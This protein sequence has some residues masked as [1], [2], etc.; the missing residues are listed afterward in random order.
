MN[1]PYR[2]GRQSRGADTVPAPRIGRSAMDRSLRHSTTGDAGF[3]LPLFVDEV[4]P[5]D[6][7]RMDATIFGRLLSPLSVPS[8]DELILDCQAF[9]VPFRLLWVNWKRF[10][11][12]RDNPADHNDFLVPQLSN[13]VGGAGFQRHS[14]ADYFGVRTETDGLDIDALFHRAYVKIWNDFYR[15]ENLQDMVDFP[16]DDGPDDAEDYEL[17]KRGK[18]KDYLTGA[19]PFVQK[20]P[21][22]E[23]PIGV[24]APLV[25]IAPVS[26]TPG[27]GPDFNQ[28]AT[29]GPLSV[30]SGDV[31]FGAGTG[32]IDWSDPN[33]FTSLSGS[34]ATAD[35]SAATGININDFRELV[36]TQ[37]LFE[38][39]ARGGTRYVE[40]LQQHF[41]VTP[42]DSRL[43]RAEF[44]WSH[45]QSLSTHV[46]AS[47]AQVVS[48]QATLAGYMQGLA[49]ARGFTKS[50]P[51]HGALMVMVSVRAPLRY[52][53][54]V[55]R[56]L[57]RRN[58]F[59][60]YWNDFALLGE[61][62]VYNYEIFAQGT[63][64][65]NEVFGYQPRYEEYRRREGMITG[66]LRSDDPL[67]LDVFHLAQKFDNLPGLNGEFIEEDPPVDRI[68]A[69][70]EEAQLLFD[71]NFRV[72]HVRPMPMFANPGLLRL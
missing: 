18:R 58:R 7:V 36:A 72:N 24:S 9:F 59:D 37:H 22:V 62:P 21:D 68:T 30:N 46:V 39:D 63:S 31:R 64:E 43:Q 41:D 53:Q 27:T 20:G 29:T 5:G 3:L 60:F 70:N 19:L 4:L 67:P 48:A 55:P 16:T 6:T 32:N 44:L 71:C 47:T 50:F 10:M 40:L 13:P 12:E 2:S 38:R 65:D 45:S 1:I 33:L 34:G 25:G 23:I 17:L 66:A 49:S 69:V 51:E 56:F 11:G 35:L 52:Q 14:L 26:F 42:E 15:D 8:L 54:N 61:Q 57:K 28:G